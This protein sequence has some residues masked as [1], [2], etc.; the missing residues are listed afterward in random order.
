MKN[1]NTPSQLLRIYSRQILNLDQ[2]EDIDTDGVV[3]LIT[4][5]VL[6]DTELTA[7]ETKRVAQLDD[8]L[9]SRRQILAQIL[10]NPNFQD[11]G[12]WWWFLHEGPQVREQTKVLA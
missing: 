11:R 10:P 5:D 9:V 3:V 1:G 6:A 2:T 8:E 7:D 4:R 12:H